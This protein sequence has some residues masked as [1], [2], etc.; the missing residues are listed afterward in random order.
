MAGALLGLVALLAPAGNK[1]APQEPLKVLRVGIVTPTDLGSPSATRAAFAERLEELG[2]KEGHNL[3]IDVVELGREQFPVAMAELVR[4][5]VDVIVAWGPETALKAVRAATDTIPIV[6]IAVDY[7]PIAKG[8]VSSLARPG[9]NITGVFFQQIELTAKRLELLKGAVPDPARVIFLWDKIS[10]DQLEP[11]R[12]AASSL[13]LPLDSVEL[14][15]PPYD[16]ERA[17]AGTDGARRDV[18]LMPASPFFGADRARLVEAALRHRLPSMFVRRRFVQSEHADADG[19]M[20]YGP[21]DTVMYR[22]AADYVDRISKGAKPADLP[23]EQPTKFELV[24]NL[25]TAKALALT[26]PQ[27]ILARAD[28]VIE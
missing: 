3:V 1:A 6:I 5:P 25:K 4:R 13:N 8:Y 22:L 15:D 2:Y 28:E 21:S 12:A 18:L 27:S 26:I 10:A 9:G 17:L 14:R 19:L 7:D 20:S 23:V 16:Y 24:V 11:A